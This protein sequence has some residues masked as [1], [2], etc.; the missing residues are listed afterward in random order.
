MALSGWQKPGFYRK[1][2][3]NLGMGNGRI[4]PQP[5]ENQARKQGMVQNWVKRM[6]LPVPILSQRPRW[7]NPEAE[8]GGTVFLGMADQSSHPALLHAAFKDRAT[9]LGTQPLG[10]TALIMN[11]GDLFCVE[12]I[13]F[14]SGLCAHCITFWVYKHCRVSP[15]SASFH[16]KI[17]CMGQRGW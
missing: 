2:S 16:L 10:V 9:L 4:L 15:Q 6:E 1:C 13:L 3:C 17:I 5:T 12:K 8:I 7:A 14:A 11:S